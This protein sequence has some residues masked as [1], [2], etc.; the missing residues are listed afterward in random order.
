MTSPHAAEWTR[1]LQEEFASLKDLGV[2]RLVPRSSVPSGRRIMRGRPVFKLKRDEH[3]NPSRFKARYVCRGYSAVYGQDYTKTTSPTARMESFRVLAHLGAAMDWEIE[4]LDIKTAFLNGVLDADEICYMDQPEGFV[5]PGFED[6]VWELQRGLYGMKQGGCVWNKTLH[7]QLVNWHFIRLECEYCIYYRRDANGIVIIGIHVDDFFMLGDS[8]HALSHFKTQLQ[9][10][11]QISD[12]GPAH[13][14]IGIA[15]ERDRAARTLAL[16]QT[17]L[18]DRVVSQFG[19]TDAHPVAIPFESGHYLLKDP[20][21]RSDDEHATMSRTPYRELVG[22]L[23]YLAIGTRPDI[24]F[25]VN[26]LCRFLDCYG[27]THWEAA[28][29]V[30]R[31]LKGTRDFRLVL[32]GEHV[33]R[34]LGY[35]DSDYALC[36]DTCRSTSGYCFSLG[37]GLISWSS[38]RQKL[39]TLSTCEAEYV[40]ASEASQE[41]VWL[42]NLLAGLQLRQPTASPLLCD[43]NGAIV[44]SSDPAFHTKLKHTDIKYHFVRERVADGQVYLHRV[45]SKDNVADAFTKA[46]PRKIFERHRDFMG[47]QDPMRGGVLRQDD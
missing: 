34:L 32:G 35:T 7:T 27:K 8:K 15:I 25:A 29:R 47:L 18:I 37:S 43:N 39:V 17:A 16:S 19:L 41:L 14:H 24:V 10:R 42:R 31:Y 26:Q 38:R 36:P 6:C 3:G 28:K 20:S 22:S 30:V 33:V 9:T 40:A 21:P 2:Y 1:A 46:L 4:Q 5:E 11:W 44:V 45:A 12:G 13:F 23:M